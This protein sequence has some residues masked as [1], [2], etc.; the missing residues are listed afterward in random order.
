MKD[1]Y[2]RNYHLYF[3]DLTILSINFKDP[4]YIYQK[5]LLLFY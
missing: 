4:I 1:L 3:F 2:L 5:I